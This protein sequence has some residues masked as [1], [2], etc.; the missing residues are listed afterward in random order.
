MR[1][2]PILIREKRFNLLP[3]RYL[4][5]GMEQR[6][7]RVEHAWDV[8]ASWG[9]RAG[10]YFRVRCQDNQLYDLFHDVEL[11]AWFVKPPRLSVSRSLRSTASAKGKQRWTFT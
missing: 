2:E 6:V 9:Q 4:H 1:Q 7:R 10:R 5:R 8:G 11:N 3:Y